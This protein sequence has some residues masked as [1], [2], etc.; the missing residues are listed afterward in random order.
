MKRDIE[1]YVQKCQSCQMNKILGPRPKE[2][3]EI[4][5][6]RKPFKRCALDIVGKTTMT[7]KGNRYILTFQD[8]LTNFVVAEL[9]PTQDAERGN[10]CTICS[11]IWNT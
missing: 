9:I 2:P 11:Q 10:S 5:A 6:A 8:D 3:M 4:T 7:N 1:N